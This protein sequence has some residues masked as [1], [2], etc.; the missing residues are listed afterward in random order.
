[1]YQLN[2]RGYVIYHYFDLIKLHCH[3]ISL[4][5]VLSDF[6][7]NFIQSL[8]QPRPCLNILSYKFLPTI[9]Y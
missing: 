8:S 2:L 4:P 1:M 9:I 5:F 7:I 3:V 6:T